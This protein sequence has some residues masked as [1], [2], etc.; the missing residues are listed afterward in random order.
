MK[1]P[2]PNTG[3]NCRNRGR[4][5]AYFNHWAVIVVCVPSCCS[6]E[7]IGLNMVASL[8]GDSVPFCLTQLL[9]LLVMTVIVE[10]VTEVIKCAKKIYQK[11]NFLNIF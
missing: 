11:K 7:D 9:Q 4:A 10:Y 3:K 5:P 6:L 1:E 2:G 8:F